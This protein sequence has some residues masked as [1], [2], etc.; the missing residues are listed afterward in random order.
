MFDHPDEP[1]SPVVSWTTEGGVTTGV[2]R[3]EFDLISAETEIDPMLAAAADGSQ[4]IELDGTGVT[5]DRT[6]DGELPRVI[7]SHLTDRR[8]GPRT[9]LSGPGCS[10]AT[11]CSRVRA[12]RPAP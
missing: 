9:A 11:G 3:G 1:H 2:L 10:R 7:G 8:T 5:R 6:V 4:W 12:D